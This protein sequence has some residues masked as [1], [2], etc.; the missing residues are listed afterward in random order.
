M[1]KIVVVGSANVDLVAR[2]P[3]LPIPG[4][5]VLGSEFVQVMGGK[6]A[7]QAVAAAK[8]GAEVSFVAAIGIDTYGDACKTSYR[9]VGIDTRFLQR[10]QDA[11]TGIALIGVAASGE[12]SIIV[13]P[14]ANSHLRSFHVDDAA[15]AIRNAD[16]L[17]VQLEIPAETVGRAVAIA[18]AAGTRVILNPAPFRK[19]SPDLLRQI[20]VLTPNLTEAEQLLGNVLGERK[21]LAEQICALGVENV[22]MTMGAAGAIAANTEGTYTVPAFPVDAVDS[23]GAGDAF[24]AG[25]AI[26]LA[27]GANLREAAGFASAAAA[28]SVTRIGAQPSLPTR[29]EVEALLATR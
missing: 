4:E 17:M 13:V 14:G 20:N 16:A 8:L 24:N 26:A 27:E 10:T 19:L 21:Q 22:V 1:S 18:H 12:N 5:T 3:A 29:A 2:V 23:T 25:L 15:D 6:G 9:S 7:N 28:V 11:A